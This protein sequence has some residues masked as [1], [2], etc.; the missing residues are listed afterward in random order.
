MSKKW[1]LSQNH[2]VM[3]SNMNPLWHF[4]RYGRKELRLWKQP[5]WFVEAF[6]L[7]GWVWENSD[8]FFG[9]TRMDKQLLF[10]EYNNIKIYR[11]GVYKNEIKAM[12]SK[13][14]KLL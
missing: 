4:I 1:Y 7:K 6:S 3:K 9:L 14:S 8:I 13:S 12:K 10:K 5:K 2:D 11:P